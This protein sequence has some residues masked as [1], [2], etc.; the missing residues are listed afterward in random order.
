MRFKINKNINLISN[1]RHLTTEFK[2][3]SVE[4]SASYLKAFLN[5]MQW[6]VSWGCG[7]SSRG[8]TIFS[9]W[10]LFIN[11]FSAALIGLDQW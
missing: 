7:V 10:I 11:L 9:K 6:L 2:L 1:I 8:M 5:W 3:I 4:F